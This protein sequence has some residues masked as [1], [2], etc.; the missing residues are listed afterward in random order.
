MNVIRVAF[1][2]YVCMQICMYANMDG[3]KYYIYVCSGGQV[4]GEIMLQK[5]YAR[6]VFISA[7]NFFL[8]LHHNLFNF[9]LQLLITCYNSIK[10]G[11]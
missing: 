7:F 2:L 1:S 10:I 4:T 11:K 5:Y 8:I 3:W 9:N 6:T